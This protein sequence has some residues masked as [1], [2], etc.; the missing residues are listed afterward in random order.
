MTGSKQSN[1]KI[2]LKDAAALLG[3]SDDLLAWALEE[4]LLAGTKDKS[5]DWT[6]ARKQVETG[7]LPLKEQFAEGLPEE[8]PLPAS[9]ADGLVEAP[10]ARASPSSDEGGEA[11]DEGLDSEIDFLRQVIEET[12]HE[13]PFQASGGAEQAP[14]AHP[15]G[16]DLESSL[17]SQLSFLRQLVE[18]QNRR[19]SDKD[20][21]VAELARSIAA[22]AEEALNRGRS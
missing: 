1:D 16:Q 4:Q 2:A 18:D 7:Q 19:L 3:L 17:A 14:Y 21:V 22:L 9:A 11:P 6:L 20:Q 12:A 15:K 5:G 8:Q 13:G 10:G